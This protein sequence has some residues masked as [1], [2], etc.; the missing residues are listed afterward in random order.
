MYRGPVLVALVA[1]DAACVMETV[2]DDVIVGRC[3]A[4][5]KEIFGSPAVSLVSAVINDYYFLVYEEM[6]LMSFLFIAKRMRSYSLESGPMG[7]RF[8]FFCV[9]WCIWQ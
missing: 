7:P 8:I 1:G 2:S 9:G 4:V 5:L 6:L 3:I